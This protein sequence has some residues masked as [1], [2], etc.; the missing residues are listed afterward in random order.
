MCLFGVSEDSVRSFAS[1]G[2]NF[3]GKYISDMIALDLKEKLSETVSE[4]MESGR[5][6]DAMADFELFELA[7]R[8][9]NS[10]YEEAETP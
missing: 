5:I 2:I 3:G 7:E 1:A 10:L 6:D 9:K 4:L 8:M